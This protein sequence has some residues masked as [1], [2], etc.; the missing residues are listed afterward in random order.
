MA[1]DLAIHVGQQRDGQG[2]G[3][4]Q[5]IHNRAFAATSVRRLGKGSPGEGSNDGDIAGVLAAQRGH[6]QAPDHG[7]GLDRSARHSIAEQAL[8]GALGQDRGHHRLL[9]GLTK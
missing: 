1:Q 5:R 6:R 7:S 2:P 3:G 9:H 8:E 4:A